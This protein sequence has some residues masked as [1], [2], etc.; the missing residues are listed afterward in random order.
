[1]LI[2]ASEVATGLRSVELCGSS[3]ARELVLVKEAV[4][5]A[6]RRAGMSNVALSA[7]LGVHTSVVS[8][9]YDS[10]KNRMSVSG[11][12]SDVVERILAMILEPE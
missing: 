10:A 6:G 8:R 4:L 9:R 12:I 3:K 5:L 11:E 7:A 2:K 1:V